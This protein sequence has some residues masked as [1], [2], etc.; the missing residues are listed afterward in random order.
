MH[1]IC[2]FENTGPFLKLLQSLLQSQ[3]A[4]ILQTTTNVLPIFFCITSSPYTK[5]LVW[6]NTENAIDVNI[7]CAECAAEKIKI[8]IHETSDKLGD[9]LKRL[10]IENSALFEVYP[11]LCTH[12]TEIQ[13]LFETCKNLFQK[14]DSRIKANLLNCSPSMSKHVAAFCTDSFADVWV[15]LAEDEDAQVRNTFSDV[16]GEV[17]K[18]LHANITIPQT[19]K[20]AIFAKFHKTLKKLTKLS[21]QNSDYEL[22]KSLLRSIENVSD[23]QSEKLTL[24]VLE[25]LLYFTMIP[26]SKYSFVATNIFKEMA[27]KRATKPRHLY[28]Q[29]KTELCKIIAE[30]CV[31]NQALVNADLATSLEKISLCFGYFGSK[32]FVSQECKFLL[33]F[34]VA[35]VVEM[36]I[37]EE[38]IKQMATM[39]TT[40]VSELL[41]RR[42][43]NVFLHVYLHK[44]DDVRDKVMR[45]LESTT[46]MNEPNL[47]KRSFQVRA[48]RVKDQYTYSNS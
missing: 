40:T 17:L 36:P 13:T 34:L 25:L 4:T 27:E 47:R 19:T 2:I 11:R 30:L 8:S 44:S 35:L 15:P 1:G 45:Y 24:F 3:N 46:K 6:N 41:I 42:Y 16:I 22:Q 12:E 37:V 33:P 14:G 39:A 28:M 20:E 38:L 29:N 43:G 7:I 9:F 31:V 5:L 10:D 26:T 23:I 18:H 48:V 32:D 21:L